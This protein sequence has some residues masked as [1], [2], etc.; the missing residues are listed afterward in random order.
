MTGTNE[1][2]SVLAEGKGPLN[3][4]P[5]S[6]QQLL[7]MYPRKRPSFKMPIL[8]RSESSSPINQFD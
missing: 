3:T 6:G 1:P 7:D 8:L 2:S 4:T 5:G